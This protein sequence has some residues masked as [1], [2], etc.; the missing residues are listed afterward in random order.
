MILLEFLTISFSSHF[1][2]PP[3]RTRA[4]EAAW[5]HRPRPG[6]LPGTQ[7]NREKNC[8]SFGYLSF[9]QPAGFKRILWS[10]GCSEI[11]RAYFCP[12]S[13]QPTINLVRKK[14]YQK[15]YFQMKS[16]TACSSKYTQSSGSDQHSLCRNAC[17]VVSQAY[18]FSASPQA[19][20]L[21]YIFFQK[22]GE[23]CS[24]NQL[25]HIAFTLQNCF[26]GSIPDT[27]IQSQPKGPLINSKI[28]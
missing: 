5:R 28:F 1:Q 22:R 13:Q 8:L 26:G 3:R 25:C 23:C 16:S 27:C 2:S 6:H 4:A 14:I 15:T 24:T 7:F 12:E 20:R 19:H 18:V 17:V 9:G 10:Q 21:I 11:E